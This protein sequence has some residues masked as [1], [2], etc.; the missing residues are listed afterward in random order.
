[1]S[2]ILSLGVP[3]PGGVWFLEGVPG[4]SGFLVPGGGAWSWGV[5]FRGSGPMGCEEPPPLMMTTAVG[6]KHPTGMH[7]YC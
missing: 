7:S 4:P 1:M 2:R 5:W 3:G 6:G